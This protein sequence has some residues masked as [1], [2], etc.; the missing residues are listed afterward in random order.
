[1]WADLICSTVEKA[2]QSPQ[3]P[4]LRIS[5]REAQLVLQGARS[6]PDDCCAVCSVA[7]SFLGGGRCCNLPFGLSIF[8][9]PSSARNSSSDQ[10]AYLVMPWIARSALGF[11]ACSS[12]FL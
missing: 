5:P 9:E 11:V 7:V 10:S 4:W 6:T 2:Q 12:A 3:Y 8:L 1:M